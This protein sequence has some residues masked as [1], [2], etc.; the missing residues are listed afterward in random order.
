MSET[1]PS[2]LPCLTVGTL[3]EEALI[4]R[5]AERIGAPRAPVTTGIGD[6]CAVAEHAAVIPAVDGLQSSALPDRVAA[7]QQVMSL[8]SNGVLNGCILRGDAATLSS[9]LDML[10]E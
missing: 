7:A 9:A 3:G 8:G 1:P 10:P 4:S 5:I 6:D 2:P